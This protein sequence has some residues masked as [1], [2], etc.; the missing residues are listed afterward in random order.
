[1]AGPQTTC[2]VGASVEPGAFRLGTLV[3]RTHNLEKG[4]KVLNFPFP[5]FVKDL[6]A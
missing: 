1:M 3:L 6:K 5:L 4:R 2:V